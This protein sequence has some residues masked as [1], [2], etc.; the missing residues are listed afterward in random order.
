MRG[1]APTRNRPERCDRL[2]HART[3]TCCARCSVARV[4]AAP[5]F[6][7]PSFEH[8]RPRACVHSVWYAHGP[9]SDDAASAVVHDA[10]CVRGSVDI[11]LSSAPPSQ[12]L[13]L[14]ARRDRAAHCRHR[15]IRVDVDEHVPAVLWCAAATYG[16]CYET[17][18]YV[19]G[20]HH[21]EH[22]MLP[23]H[24][25]CADVC[26][27]SCIDRRLRAASTTRALR[28]RW[29]PERRRDERETGGGARARRVN[30][31][32]RPCT[33]AIPNNLDACPCVRDTCAARA[34]VRRDSARECRAQ[35]SSPS[36]RL[37]RQT[38]A[39]RS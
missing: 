16:T 13:S 12:R 17:S 33:T 19:S 22:A 18:R 38:T 15:D 35:V 5:M 36:P 30:E 37:S 39:L 32:T 11:Y 3:R 20:R 23:Y 25:L 31:A 29:W 24:A 27:Q 2:S 6:A 21:G 10:I 4:C 14:K 28:T 26:T 9:R 1:T 34:G 8:V 7:Q